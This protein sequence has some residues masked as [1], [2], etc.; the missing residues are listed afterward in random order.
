MAKDTL[1]LLITISLVVSSVMS[2]S[3]PRWLGSQ[4]RRT[5]YLLSSPPDIVTDT[6]GLNDAAVFFVDNFWV[7]QLLYGA[8]DDRQRAG[9]IE[10]QKNDF[11]S[12]YG[13]LLGKRRLQS[14][15]L[16]SRCSADGAI[17]GVC[18]LELALVDRDS[19]MITHSTG[20]EQMIKGTLG[21]LGPKQRRLFKDFSVQ[22]LVKLIDPDLTVAPLL[23]NLAVDTT[24]RRSGVG[25][26]LCGAAEALCAEWGFGSGDSLLWL[27]VEEA[28]APARGLYEKKLGYKSQWACCDAA[29]R[30]EAGDPN[31]A[32][33]QV[34]VQTLALAKKLA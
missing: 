34:E 13:E 3:Q 18:G 15:L 27:E 4:I 2:F 1:L 5:T 26:A 6:P 12:R 11:V 9:L 23:S 33:R 14:A 31:G 30:I 7:P 17:S 29:L 32:F 28:N 20:G 19:E 10:I 25:A 24:A 22:D 16:V 8:V 21:A